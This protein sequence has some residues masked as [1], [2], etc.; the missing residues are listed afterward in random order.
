MKKILLVVSLMFSTLV[1]SDHQVEI[2]Y[3]LGGPDETSPQP[4]CDHFA[5]SAF[6]SDETFEYIYTTPSRPGENLYWCQIE[7]T[8]ISTGVNL[9]IILQQSLIGQERV[10]QHE[11]GENA[12]EAKDGNSFNGSY[13][14]DDVPG[15]D[16]CFSGCIANYDYVVGS[17]DMPTRW[18]FVATYNGQECSVVE[19]GATEFYNRPSG[20]NAGFNEQ[21]ENES[22]LA[23]EYPAPEVPPVDAD[24]DAAGEQPPVL[25]E[26]E[27]IPSGETV[28]AYEQE[29]GG[30]IYIV[31]DSAGN[32]TFTD[33]SPIDGSGE[34]T[35]GATVDGTDG[36][37]DGGV[38]GGVDGTTG[39]VDGG[40]DGGVDGGAD[41]AV[42]SGEDPEGDDDRSSSGGE[43]CTVA[44]SCSGDA[45]NCAIVTQAWNIRCEAEEIKDEI[46]KE[47]EEDAVTSSDPADDIESQMG[48]F[49]DG[50]ENFN[51]A[52][53]QALQEAGQFE[54]DSITNRLSFVTSN[55]GSGLF[56]LETDQFGSMDISPVMEK[57]WSPARDVMGW[58]IWLSTALAIWWMWYGRFSGGGRS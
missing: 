38:D 42:D 30:N 23:T 1:Y 10:K 5:S 31:T 9:G 4:A 13:D 8:R 15:A 3:S 29:G 39:T 24:L 51:G 47:V 35:A 46:L 36:S 53:S 26:T 16:S 17:G 33:K 19:T 43:S 11:D 50:L 14:S 27:V 21:V 28:E 48:E 57:Y 55:S 25:T 40:S 54:L 37:V 32:I 12:C 41:G 58:T 56:V 52:D 22:N 34:Y 6:P 7:R 20:E 49:S 44:P 2:V 45:I 18:F